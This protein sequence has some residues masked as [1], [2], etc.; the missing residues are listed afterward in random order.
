MSHL[1]REQAV[2]LD[3]VVCA[4][5]VALIVAEPDFL[6]ARLLQLCDWYFQKVV[7]EHTEIR[8]TALDQQD[9]FFR[10]EVL[11]L[12]D[13]LGEQA[14]KLCCRTPG[15]HLRSAVEDAIPKDAVRR[16]HDLRELN[17]DFPSIAPQAKEIGRL[18]SLDGR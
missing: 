7:C 14:V 1:R 9:V 17:A 6:K 10:R 5:T 12:A 18:R 8:V 2:Q 3:A 16:A 4:F 15:V 11:Q 13:L